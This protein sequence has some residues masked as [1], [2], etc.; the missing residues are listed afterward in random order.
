MILCVTQD[1]ITYLLYSLGV[2]I[3]GV[4]QQQFKDDH[5]AILRL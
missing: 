1:L 4:Q 3:F 5:G 2:F